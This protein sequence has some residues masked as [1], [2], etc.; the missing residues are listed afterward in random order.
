MTKYEV[1]TKLKKALK[2]IENDTKD[3]KYNVDIRIQE[4]AKCPKCGTYEGDG[5]T[6][7]NFLYLIKKCNKC[8]YNDVED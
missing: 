7:S 8:G 3:K 1:E 4:K 2:N 6:I 5:Y